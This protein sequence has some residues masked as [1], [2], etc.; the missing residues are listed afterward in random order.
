MDEKFWQAVCSA[1]SCCFAVFFLPQLYPFSEPDRP[2]FDS[3]GSG[4]GS[5]QTV[6]A[7]PAPAPTK[8]CGGSGSGSGSASLLAT[9]I[10]I[11]LR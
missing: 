11:T 9:I 6:S 2:V 1:V 7:A 10:D 3:S 4:S 5:E 8:M